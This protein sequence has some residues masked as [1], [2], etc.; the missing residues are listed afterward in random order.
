MINIIVWGMG[1]RAEKFIDRIKS[2][3]RE[4]EYKISAITD[5]SV[6]ETGGSFNDVP[7]LSKE[8]WSNIEPDCIVICASG[9]EKEIS[10]VINNL[11]G[12][13]MKYYT[14][15]DD[16]L[17]T[18]VFF[19]KQT[20]MMQKEN[21]LYNIFKN[22]KH[23]YTI[24]VLNYFDVYDK[25]FSRFRDTDVV[26]C[27]VGIY[28]GGSLQ[29]WKEYFGKNATIIGVDISEEC[30]KFEED[31]IHVEI[32]S[33]NDVNF[34]NYI[35]EKYP[36]IDIL[37]DDGSHMNEHQILTFESM[38]PH[39]S[40]NGIYLCEDV[41]TSYWEDYGGGYKKEGTMIEYAKDCI[42]VIHA[43]YFDS[44]NLINN[45]TDMYGIH[46][47]DNMVLIEKKNVLPCIVIRKENK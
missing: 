37:I 24:K 16:D 17:Y 33:Q 22:S 14:P 32:G 35:K 47:Y 2:W 30:K 45:I 34:W 12:K 11:Y 15:I 40:D 39:I 1:S 19:K 46:F 13:E 43:S 4:D 9:Y 18:D 42:D 6:K 7:I 41:D 25:W 20:D 44:H 29:M 28:R 23:K 10:K 8:N 3:K 38:F 31:Q 27:E 36:K 5:S 21:D 26:V